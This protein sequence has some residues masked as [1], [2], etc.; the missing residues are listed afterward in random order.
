MFEV[1]PLEKMYQKL[2]MILLRLV[3]DNLIQRESKGSF[4]WGRQCVTNKIK[5][6]FTNLYY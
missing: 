1:Q 6:L 2:R 3:A 4:N 5:Q